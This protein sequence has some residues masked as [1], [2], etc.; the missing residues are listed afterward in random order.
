MKII[1]DIDQAELSALIKLANYAEKNGIGLFSLKYHSFVR[2][3]D[4]A[5]VTLGNNLEMSLKKCDSINGQKAFEIGNCRYCNATF[6]IGKI[7]EKDGI[8]YLNPNKNIDL[9]ENYGAKNNP[10]VDFFITDNYID[11]D[12]S[13]NDSLE[14]C[15]LCTKCGAIYEKNNLNARKCSCGREYERSVYRV[16]S[17]NK[18]G[19]NIEQ[20]P[21]C[22]LSKG[23][24]IVNELSLGKDQSTAILG[25]ILYESMDPVNDVNERYDNNDNL[26][27]HDKVHRLN[28]KDKYVKQFIAFSDG[29]QQASY[30]AV[31][32]DAT[33]RHLIMKRLIWE[34]IE[35][36]EYRDISVD[37]M[38]AYLEKMIKDQDLF[39]NDLSATK[40]AWIC[41]LTDLLKVDGRY[42][43]EGVGLYYFDLDLSYVMP[44]IND[45]AVERRYG[46]YNL[47]KK[48]LEV[49]IKVMFE[50]FKTAP[51]IDYT[52]SSL[53][54]DEKI[55][56]FEYKG[57]DKYI[58]Y[59]ATSG[60]KKH[61]NSFV[62]LANENKVMRY[63][64]KVLNCNDK[65][66][67]NFMDDI[68]NGIGVPTEILKYNENKNAYQI[69]VSSYILKNYKTSKF[70]RC[71]KCGR[72]T[73]YNVHGVCVQDKCD[74]TLEEI[75]PD[76]IFADNYYREQYKT[77]K[78]EG[79]VIKEHTAQIERR[80][81]EE[82]QHAFKDKKINILSSSTTFEMVID[83]GSLET[84]FMRNVPPTPANYVQRAGRAGRRK[85][86]SAYILTYCGTNSHDYTYFC[87]PERMISGIIKPPYFNVINRKIIERHLMASYLGA[88]F[89]EFNEYYKS[90][91][92]FVFRGGYEKFIEFILNHPANL[93]S[94]IDERVI[95]E[96][97]FRDYHD[98]KWIDGIGGHDKKLENLIEYF[99]RTQEEYI[100]SKQEAL[101]QENY[102]EADYYS[103]QLDNLKKEN[104]IRSLSKYCVIPR[105][106]FPIDVVN[107]KVYEHGIPV[108]RLDLARDL[109]IAVSE[110]APSSEVVVD[111]KKYVS[112][113]IT[114]PK[115]GE[116][117]HYY[118]ISCDEC[119]NVNVALT[120]HIDKCRYCGADLSEKHLRF[121]IDPIYGFKA[122]ES[123]KSTRIKPNR[124]YTGAVKYIGG[125]K[126]EQKKISVK[127]IIFVETSTDDELLVMN[128]HSFFMCPVCGYSL[129]DMS[130]T[131]APILEKEHVNYK[132]KDCSN[133][134]LIKI[135]L[136]HKFR[137][138]VAKIRI[139]ELIYLIDNN[140]PFDL[141]I[142]VMYALLEG[143]SDALEINRRDID[144]LLMKN[145]YNGGY[146]I[147]LYDNVPGGAG[148]VK[149]LLNEESIKDILNAALKKV[150]QDCCEETTSC[151]KC[152]RNYYNEV[153]HNRLKRGL[154][155][156]ALEALI[157]E[158]SK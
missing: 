102:K 43:G 154:A 56:Y 53:L 59:Q 20:C 150:S 6:I 49:M 11:E 148:Y 158:I 65:D 40:N 15:V 58:Q 28:K 23:S 32:F 138:D 47:T 134:K 18:M 124:T 82:Y 50:I 12:S 39:H 9:Y 94:Y 126:V 112:Q 131:G 37:Q 105:Y 7:I 136:G 123:K 141:S 46:R 64:K 149:R 16:I 97:S 89:R 130:S 113:Y 85:G 109:R 80:K 5:Y 26:L 118:F 4:G 24:G 157:E 13:D 8:Q 76:D 30:S 144:G 61:I 27:M 115:K 14:E 153:Y 22:G 87:E 17:S 54:N 122:C 101:E 156:K 139:P 119:D 98:F 38:A 114:L 52:K 1:N 95:P 140:E 45:E 75:D 106:G 63:V 110:Y 111:G 99:V 3:L 68:Y 121:Y 62:P 147:L 127:D 137:T 10:L 120:K 132:G 21:C 29:R 69:D 36:Y 129:K 79:V 78:I 96:D 90:V 72:V 151:Y 70:Y 60:E 55:E 48:D 146:D 100:L 152:L 25:Q 67:R 66:A 77:K 145:I 19:N 108:N 125:G 83:L 31:F 2:S 107:M 133:D 104:M 51:A 142:S 128:E 93:R 117:T 42:D 135:N 71:S 155:K 84:V 91:Y 73:P 116:F 74:G 44:K 92:D 81:A 33:Q 143:M 86:S 88:F 41:I 34:V 35:N 103:T 57:I